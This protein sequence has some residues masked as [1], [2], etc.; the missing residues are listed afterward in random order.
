MK[1]RNEVT[2]TLFQFQENSFIGCFPEAQGF[3][4]LMSMIALKQN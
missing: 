3:L 2:I 4:K 1:R